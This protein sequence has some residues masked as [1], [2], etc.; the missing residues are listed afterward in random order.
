MIERELRELAA[1]GDVVDGLARG[2]GQ[3]QGDGELHAESVVGRRPRDSLQRWLS[4][5][6]LTPPRLV[7]LTTT[8]L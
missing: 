5:Y 7:R 3:E 4:A 8:N 2:R 1:L 6:R